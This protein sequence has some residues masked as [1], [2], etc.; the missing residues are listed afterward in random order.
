M[1]KKRVSKPKDNKST[2]KSSR[3]F[4]SFAKEKAPESFDIG[5]YDTTRLKAGS[6][7]FT[8]L[9]GHNST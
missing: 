1:A 2:V 4:F 8:S 7:K 3:H 5:K 9:Y 6:L